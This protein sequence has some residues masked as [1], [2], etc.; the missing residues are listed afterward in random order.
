MFRAIPHDRVMST[1]TTE[2]FFR[3]LFLLIALVFFYV[4]VRGLLGHSIVLPTKF[5][6][7]QRFRGRP[8]R[9]AGAVAVFSG[10]LFVCAYWLTFL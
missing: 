4:G 6:G 2:S 3:F 7:L 10:L 9:V 1:H 5:S 8:A